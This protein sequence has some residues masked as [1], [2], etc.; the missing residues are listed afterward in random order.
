[1]KVLA[2]TMM[3]EPAPKVHFELV[4]CAVLEVPITSEGPA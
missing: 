3:E 4:T 1:M 2:R